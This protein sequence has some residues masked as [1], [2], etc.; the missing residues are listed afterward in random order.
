ND[1]YFQRRGAKQ[2]L[3]RAFPGKG[4]S[5]AEQ[6]F[7][8]L[9][10]LTGSLLG[11]AWPVEREGGST[12][13][14]AIDLCLVDAGA[15]TDIIVNWCRQQRNP[16]IM[17]SRGDGLKPSDT[18]I[19]ERTAKDGQTLGH[20]WMIHVPAKRAIRHVFFDTN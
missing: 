10:E 14:L 5:R 11:K 9:T 6:L 15:D 1:A 2:T 12:A 20:H 17:P 3:A 18:P 7:H 19:P 16:R 8:G 13:E 4:A